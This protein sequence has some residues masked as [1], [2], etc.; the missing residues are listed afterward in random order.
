MEEYYFYQ[1]VQRTTIKECFMLD[2]TQLWNLIRVCG[3]IV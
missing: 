1:I 2:K 3:S